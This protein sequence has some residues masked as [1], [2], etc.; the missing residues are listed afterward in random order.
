M[1]MGH[2]LGVHQLKSMGELTYL[3]KWSELQSGVRSSPL[4]GD[5]LTLE[6]SAISHPGHSGSPVL[7]PDGL[8]VGVMSNINPL[9]SKVNRAIHVIHIEELLAE[10]IRAA[11]DKDSLEEVSLQLNEDAESLDDAITELLDA[12]LTEGELSDTE[13]LRLVKTK[14]FFDRIQSLEKRRQ[15]LAVMRSKHGQRSRVYARGGGPNIAE[16]AAAS[17]SQFYFGYMRSGFFLY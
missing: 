15:A 2:G 12:Q 3:A 17:M 1:V 9:Q 16:S 10:V 6:T 14:R 11:V 7:T 5:T 4:S 8:V 13:R